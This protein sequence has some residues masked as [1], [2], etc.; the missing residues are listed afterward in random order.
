MDTR[1]SLCNCSTLAIIAEIYIRNGQC[2]KATEALM[3]GLKREPYDADLVP[4]LIKLAIRAKAPSSKKTP[5]LD[6][7]VINALGACLTCVNSV[8]EVEAKEKGENKESKT[9]IIA[10]ELGPLMD[11]FVVNFEV[12]AKEVR[13][14]PHLIAAAKCMVLVSST[15]TPPTVKDAVAALFSISLLSGRGVSIST[16]T[17]ALAF[18][19][20][21]FGV[22]SDVTMAFDALV[23][24]AYPLYIVF[25]SGSACT[26][27]VGGV[28]KGVFEKGVS[29]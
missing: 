26:I 25:Q 22:E 3:A 6:S 2:D 15:P 11:A 24:D 8:A 18:L 10:S 1:F 17:A 7:S 14:L 13:S 16:A 29:S 19:Q 5:A 23:K 4:V 20:S 12:K 9:A 28:E 21:T 27:K